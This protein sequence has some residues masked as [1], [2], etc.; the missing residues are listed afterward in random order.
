MAAVALFLLGSFE[1][2]PLRQAR[3]KAANVLGSLWARAA[4]RVEA[5]LSRGAK[6]HPGA[7][8]KTEAPPPMKL[9]R[10]GHVSVPG[11][12]LVLP[13]T[14]DTT[15]GS[16]DLLIHFHGN[17]AVVKES[18]EVAKLNA[19]VAIINLGV[20]S[21]PYEEYYAEPGTYEELLS[22]VDH[23]LKQRGVLTPHLRR[24][25]LSG[26]SAGYGAVSTILHV[27]KR[28]DPLDAVLLFDGIHCSW[29]GAS[30]AAWA[31]AGASADPAGMSPELAAA[32]SSGAIN[33]RQLGSFLEAA[34]DA[35][36]G[37][38]YFG[39][40]HSEIDPVT[41][42]STTLASGYLV[43]EVGAETTPL[44]PVKDAPSYVELESM[45]NAVDHSKEKAMEPVS[46]SRKGS[47]HV[48]AYKGVTQEHHMAHLFEMSQTL[49]PELVARWSDSPR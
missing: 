40:T 14:F 15:D 10:W 16:Y 12:I 23:G 2:A 43:K 29:E 46:E 42:A 41:Y 13:S 26:W 38:I 7:Y 49:L 4:S 8:T 9:N 31:Q 34:K 28:I 6:A 36:D 25:A 5:D 17:T 22:A 3:A 37:R 47:F 21:G 32:R 48:L 33:S 11:G 44:D 18:V 30:S 20:G 1:A 45:A 19:A 39:I 27:R 24:V 35:A